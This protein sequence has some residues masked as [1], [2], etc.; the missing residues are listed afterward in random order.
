MAQLPIRMTPVV[1]TRGIY[2]LKSPF[3]AASDKLYKCTAV[4]GYRELIDSG[5]DIFKE[6]YESLGLSKS[7]YQEDLQADACIC[8]L[9]ADTGETIYVPDTYI[10]G[11]PDQSVPEIGLFVISGIIG[12]VR[13]NV[14]L[15]H[16]KAKVAEII[17]DTT[18]LEPEIHVDVLDNNSVMTPVQA[19][20]LETARIA[21]IKNRETTYAEVLRLRGEN[22]ALR[23]EIEVLNNLLKPTA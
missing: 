20:S 13:L 14:D 12:P 5:K 2:S 21:R 16:M 22:E 4:R 11:L 3:V 23:K 17:S 19:A 8:A 6:Y 1:Y 18:G 15:S 10:V 9:R 7:D